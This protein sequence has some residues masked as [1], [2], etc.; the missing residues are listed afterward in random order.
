MLHGDP[1]RGITFLGRTEQGKVSFLHTPP[2]RLQVKTQMACSVILCLL[3]LGLGCLQT[4]K[5]IEDKTTDK[6]EP[7]CTVSLCNQLVQQ[8]EPGA[9]APILGSG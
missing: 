3:F 9:I 8:T 1:E 6:T 4:T 5:T 7:Q 2:S